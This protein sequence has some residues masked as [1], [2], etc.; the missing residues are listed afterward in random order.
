MALDLSKLQSEVAAEA[1]IE[2]AALK[3]LQDLAASV[4]DLKVQLAAAIAANDPAALKAL[5]DT[6][7]A[8]DKQL[9]AD[10]AELGAALTPP[11]PPPA[12]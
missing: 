7:D 12:V 5:Q 4:A 1:T 6:V 2:K 3:S 10:N 11:P 9:A 8:L